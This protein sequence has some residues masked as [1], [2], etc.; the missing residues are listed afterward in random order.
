MAEAES[1]MDAA[2]EAQSDTA[3][4]VEPPIMTVNASYSKSG[5]AAATMAAPAPSEHSAE[6]EASKPA[7]RKRKYNHLVKLLL[8]GDS[9]ALSQP[10]PDAVHSA[11]G[12]KGW[13]R[14][15]S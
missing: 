11:A 8:V 10:H 5:S 1:N 15:V 6:S 12:W 4:T 7:R 3:A 2:T 13:A 9:G 14:H